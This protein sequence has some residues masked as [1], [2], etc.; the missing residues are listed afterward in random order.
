MCAGPG[1]KSA[2]LAAIAG[3]LGARLLASERQVHRAGLVASA[4]TTAGAG[5]LGVVAADG[6]RPAWRD[7]AFDRV[8]VDAPC[9]GLGALRRRPEARW[10][11]SQ[12]DVD[13]L[14]PL[15]HDLL[16]SAVDAVRP[17]GRRRL[18]DLLPGARRDGRRRAGRAGRAGR[19]TTWRT[20]RRCSTASTDLAGP[21]PGTVQL[22]PHRHGTDAMFVAL[23]RRELGSAPPWVS[24]SPRACSR[25]TS[26]TSPPRRRAST[27]ADWLHVDVMDNHFVPNLTIGLPVV[28]A[29]GKASSTPMDCHLMI[30]DPD[31][32]APAYVEA[33]AAVRDLPR[34]GGRGSGPAGAR[35]AGQG[36]PR[37]AWA[38]SRRRR[39]TP[40]RTCCPSSTCCW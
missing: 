18:R 23:L 40:T 35:A 12:D 26:P 10:R 5:L 20:R 14:V 16:T 2:L 3:G 13:G 32:W 6:T 36:C 19:R 17:G 21:M 4:T 11:R 29:L 39:S 30:E 7:G 38:S 33:G 31:R 22:W 37:R 25:P 34:R 1:G 28:E 27:D 24:R 15:Q 9:S 8:L